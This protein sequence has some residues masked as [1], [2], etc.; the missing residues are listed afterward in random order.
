MA[1]TSSDIKVM[2]SIKTGSAGDTLAQSDP[3]ESLG[4]YVSTTEASSNVNELFDVVTGAENAASDVE[5]RCVFVKNTH[6]TLTYLS[7]V[8]FMS[9]PVSGGAA[10]AIGLDTTAKSDADSASAQ[11]LEVANESTAPSGVS[12]ST[13]AIDVASGLSIGDLAPDEVKAIWIRRT[14]ANTAALDD[15]GFTLSFSGDSAA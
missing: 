10:A 7:S 5:Y 15:D 6:A 1:I 14:A 13:S 12:F 3:N 4:K 11:A 2:L 9:S 8:V